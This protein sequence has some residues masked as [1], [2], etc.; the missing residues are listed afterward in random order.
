LKKKKKKDEEALNNDASP[1]DTDI[2]ETST[3]FPLTSGHLQ[4]SEMELGLHTPYKP[5]KVVNLKK[6]RFDKATGRI[7]Q[8]QTRKSQLPEETH[9]QSS[10][11]LW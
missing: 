9:C 5:N 8:Q 3:K 10:Q 11:R 7:V 1:M 6:F 4:V 2:L